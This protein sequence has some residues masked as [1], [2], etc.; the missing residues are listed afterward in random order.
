M[1]DPQSHAECLDF[2]RAAIA[3]ADADRTQIWA[4]LTADERAKF[5]FL[6]D[7]KK[8]QKPFDADSERP[9]SNY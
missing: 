7:Y 3:E 5:S 4:E 6:T 9:E 2:I 8:P 1:L